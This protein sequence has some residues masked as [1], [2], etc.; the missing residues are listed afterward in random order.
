[1]KLFLALVLSAAGIAAAGSTEL[2]DDTLDISVG[3]YRYV[4][5]R[6]QPAQTDSAVIRGSIRVNPDTTALEIMLFHVDDFIR[7]R[8]LAADT[9]TL[10]YSR[11]ASGNLSIPVSS[12]G[13]Y[14][15]V[16]SNRGNMT[17]VSVAARFTL[18]FEGSGVEYDSLKIALDIALL[19]M[20]VSAII[21][22]VVRAFG[23]VKKKR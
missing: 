19:L 5:F 15:L 18:F 22:L 1:M 7:W 8:N 10:Y 4:S 20:A 14:Y 6:V 9:D 11:T 21:V 2:L 13:D 16:L 12:C 17:P 23:M 3:Q